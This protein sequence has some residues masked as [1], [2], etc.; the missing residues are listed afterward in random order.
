MRIRRHRLAA[1]LAGAAA[2]GLAAPAAA[3]AQEVVPLEDRLTCVAPSD[4]AGIDLML[5]AA[6]SPLAGQGATFVEQAGAVGLDPR[7]LVAIAAHETLLETYPPARLIRNPFGLG[8]GLSYAS[9]ADAIATAA[10][11]LAGGYLAEGRTTI[12]TIGAKWAPVG[13]VNDPTGLN[14][15]W[16]AGVSRYY[17]ALGG[18]PSQPLLL[19]TQDG[20]PDCG[21]SA[22]V[23]GA[24]APPDAVAG[25]P[26]VTA[27]GGAAPRAAGTAP[28]DGA[29]P[30]SGEPATLEGFVFPLALP[31]GAP[32]VYADDFDEPGS[33]ECDGM[34]WRCSILL[35][36]APA[37]AAVA[38]AAGLLQVATPADQE[39]GIAFWITTPGGDRLGYGPLAAYSAG[40]TDGTTVTVG[41][42]LGAIGG[43]MRFAWTR[44]GERV[45]PFPLL[46]A[47]RPP[48]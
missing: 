17:A 8:P 25:P 3:P 2:L 29:D 47:T 27:W 35:A 34:A 11:I 45:N 16:P 21:P 10:Q 9:E 46:E 14:P 28:R 43:R 32:A 30:I 12:P 24:G 42:P 48:G 4:A 13:A 31:A 15:H 19:A 37:T 39:G 22:A 38:S 23:A 41:Q 7:A 1:L 33:A 20:V 5:A 44:R 36:S 6:A 26:L 18:D 40:I